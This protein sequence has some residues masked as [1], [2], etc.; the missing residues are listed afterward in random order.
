MK[1][2]LDE[3]R[4]CRLNHVMAILV[5]LVIYALFRERAVDLERTRVL[6]IVRL[7]IWGCLSLGC[8]SGILWYVYCVVQV[9]FTIILFIYSQYTVLLL[10]VVALNSKWETSKIVTV[11]RKLMLSPFVVDWENDTQTPCHCVLLRRS[12]IYCCEVFELKS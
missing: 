4:A 8:F 9:F 11:V 7:G 6:C 5:S 10:H 1:E 3:T 2:K 12:W